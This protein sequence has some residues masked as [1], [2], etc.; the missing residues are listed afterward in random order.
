[1]KRIIDIVVSLCALILLS[2]VLLVIG[3]V[4]WASMGWPVFFYQVRSG[5]HGRPFTIVKFR[6]MRTATEGDGTPQPDDR[7]VTNV[8]RVLRSMSL[9]ELPELWN[10]LRGEMSLVGPRPLLVDYLTLY[11]PRQARRHQVRPGLTGWAQVNGRNTIS[12]EQKFEYDVWYVDSHSVLLDFAYCVVKESTLMG[13]QQLQ[14][15]A[16]AHTLISTK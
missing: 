15:S 3:I 13:D 2:P 11:S 14:F 5:L 6:T 7:R 12:W 1:M 9:D 8:G 10:V 16:E 4:V